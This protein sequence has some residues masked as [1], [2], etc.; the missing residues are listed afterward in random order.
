M[1]VHCN[2]KYSFLVR[3]FAHVQ[4]ETHARTSV[5]VLLIRKKNGKVF[6]HGVL[7]SSKNEL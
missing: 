1:Y 2:L 4:K 6:I 7:Y 5:A 3:F